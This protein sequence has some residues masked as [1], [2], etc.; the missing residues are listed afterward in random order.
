M[1]LVYE[2]EEM[3]ESFSAQAIQIIEDAKKIA[4][5]QSSTVV[6]TEHLLLAMYQTPDSIC[7]FLL[8]EKNITYEMLL[9]SLNRLTIIH[10]KATSDLMFTDKFQELV[11]KA[12][13]FIETIDSKY[14]FDEHLFYV[15]LKDDENAGNE[16]LKELNINIEY[17][18]EDIEDIFN[19]YKDE[20]EEEPFPYLINLTKKSMIHPFIKRSNYIERISYIL[21]KKQKNNPLLIGSAGVGKTS[22]I[23]GLSKIR[24]DDII[25]QLD[26]GGVVAGTKYRGELEEK[27]LKVMDFI[28]NKKA[29]LFIDEIHNV[30]GSGSNEGSLDIANILKPYLSKT[31]ISVIGATTLDEYYK[32]IDKDKALMRRFQTV[33]IDEPTISETKN[34]LMKIKDKYEEYH[35][36]KFT[37]HDI[38]LIIDKC[39][40]YLPQRSFPDKAIDVLDEVGSRYHMND[41]TKKK[42]EVI[43]E[44]IQDISN[45]HILKFNELKIAKLNYDVLKPYYFRFMEKIMIYPNIFKVYVNSDF[46]ISYL[47]DD[48]YLIFNFKKEMLLEI[49]LDNYKDS[50]MINNLLGSSKG[51]VGYEQG[52][53]L[54]EHILKYPLSLIY[55]KNYHNIHYSIKSILDKMMKTDYFYDNKGRKINL[56]NTMFIVE[57]KVNVDNIGF[58]DDSKNLND[59]LILPTIKR[60]NNN[61]QK[62]IDKYH[63]NKDLANKI[64]NNEIKKD[65]YEIIFENL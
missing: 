12:E 44:V 31:E 58:I 37:S 51:Y 38:D 46:D 16:V 64:L 52:G 11:V 50:T 49:D 10:K 28:K 2:E 21:N 3:L 33:F 57:N 22:I 4:S 43:D 47:L 59:K 15:M 61:Y 29:I 55:F 63:L 9:D 48:L 35:N 18:I 8:Q 24:T 42:E 32:F 45:I 20:K 6:G 39:V 26:L 7:R 27:L 53:L 1:L 13:E 25:Y 14:V 60:N 36:I 17:L 41:L 23:E 5:N 30:V 34:I 40:L 65:I 19:F 54:S 62:L 56:Q